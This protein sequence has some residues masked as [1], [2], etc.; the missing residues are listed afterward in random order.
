MDNVT[1]E[2]APGAPFLS[3]RRPDACAM[4]IFGATGDLARRK[5][6]PGLYNLLRDGLLPDGCRLVALGRSV[7]N[8]D[9][10][11]KLVEEST[12]KY[13]RTPFEPDTWAKLAPRISFVHGDLEDPSTYT[14]LR[15][16]LE[17]LDKESTGGN[18][19]YYFSV[20]PSS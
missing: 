5:L 2:S 6:I 19:L 15:K 12:R 20:P 1:I 11:R 16:E 9:A 7:E 10:Y 17:R 18:R 3:E 8:A 13:S 4:V 14:E